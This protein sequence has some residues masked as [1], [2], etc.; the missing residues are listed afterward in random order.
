MTEYEIEIS[1][2]KWMDKID[3]R[4]MRNEINQKEY[5]EAV[6]SI[7]EWEKEKMREKQNTIE[8]V[9]INSLNYSDLYDFLCA[10][11]EEPYKENLTLEQIRHR[12]Y[13]VCCENGLNTLVSW[14][15]TQEGCVA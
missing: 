1:I 9:I 6:N 3:M 14:I 12:V 11:D 2:E 8:N 5:D 10:V 4:L 13:M 7:K 15:Q